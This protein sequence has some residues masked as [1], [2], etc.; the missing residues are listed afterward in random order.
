M[1]ANRR[2]SSWSMRTWLMLEEIGANYK[3]MQIQIG[4]L[5]AGGVEPLVCSKDGAIPC[6]AI[7]SERFSGALQLMEVIGERLASDE[8]W[9]R[10]VE[11]RREILNFCQ[12]LI[13][14]SNKLRIALPLTI[15]V[16]SKA[17]VTE[18]VEKE[19]RWLSSNLTKKLRVNA[20]GSFLYGRFGLA[21]CF[22]APYIL[23]F[24]QYNITVTSDLIEYSKNILGRCS[25]KTWV[26]DALR[27]PA[28]MTHLHNVD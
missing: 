10:D 4:D 5:S 12:D 23:R 2:Y 22:V 8:M 28:T 18:D 9:P 17:M 19:I 25:V 20:S 26:Q 21:D 1:I 14:H 24:K 11:E 13:L 3:T 7:G 6:V 16:A 15:G 27:E